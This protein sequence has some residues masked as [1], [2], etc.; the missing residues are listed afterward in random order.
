MKKVVYLILTFFLMSCGSQSLDNY[1]NKGP[2]LNLREFF[3]GEL[4]AY[5]IVQGRSGQVNQRFRADIK[6]SWKGNI[7]TL[8]ETFHYPD[9][10]VS[11]RV[12]KLKEIS[13]NKFT[14]TAGDV[15]GTAIGEVKGNTFFF[16]YVLAL[17]LD[18]SEY[19]IS[20]EDWMYH[21]DNKTLM[22]R[23]YMSKW[24]F[25][26]GEVSLVMTKKNLRQ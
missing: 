6:A 18:G 21:L 22:A 3:N 24:G 20:V 16:E 23:S 4:E 5:G 14:A 1:K 2:K 8:D 7:C 9:R 25:N 15:V 17:E 11:K 26:V 19:H 12:W 10:P 13:P